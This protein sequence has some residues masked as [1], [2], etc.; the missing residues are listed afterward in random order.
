MQWENRIFAGRASNFYIGMD[1]MGDDEMEMWYSQDDRNVKSSIA[2][3]RGTQVA[4]PAELVQF[5][6]V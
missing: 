2:F 4:Y 1:A 6:L 3:K 5:T